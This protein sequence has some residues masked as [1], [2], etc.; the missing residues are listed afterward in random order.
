MLTIATID[1]VAFAFGSQSYGEIGRSAAV[2]GTVLV[3]SLAIC[4]FLVRLVQESK[5]ENR[6]KSDGAE[7]GGELSSWSIL[8][9]V[10][11]IA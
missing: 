1:V 8:L 6:E 5:I 10:A 3:A 7:T 9:V 2:V 11:G 4:V